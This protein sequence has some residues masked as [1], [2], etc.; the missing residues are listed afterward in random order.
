MWYFNVSYTVIVIRLLL[1]ASLDHNVLLA[2]PL[3]S[4]LNKELWQTDRLQLMFWANSLQ[5][6]I[7]T[8]NLHKCNEAK[9][10]TVSK[11]HS[12]NKLTCRLSLYNLIGVQSEYKSH[13]CYKVQIH[14]STIPKQHISRNLISLD[15]KTFHYQ[16]ELNFYNNTAWPFNKQAAKSDYE[17]VKKKTWS[18]WAVHP[19]SW[20]WHQFQLF[21]RTLAGFHTASCSNYSLHGNM[22]DTQAETETNIWTARRPYRNRFR[23]KSSHWLHKIPKD[24]LRPC[25]CFFCI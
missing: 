20:L 12:K 11:N 24:A 10:I 5:Y 23:H 8:Y 13:V 2:N 25:L 19:D 6:K 3:K 1:L 7:K 4:P 16:F 22:P 18:G 21:T 9:M 17:P 15:L 14:W